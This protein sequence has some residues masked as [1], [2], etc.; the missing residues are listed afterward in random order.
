MYSFI[1]TTEC[2]KNILIYRY[3]SGLTAN[4]KWT[5]LKTFFYLLQNFIFNN[6]MIYLTDN[7]RNKMG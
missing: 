1:Q 2:S 3:E 7:A 5:M 6:Q 4:R